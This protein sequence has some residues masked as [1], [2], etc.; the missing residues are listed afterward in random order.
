MISAPRCIGGLSLR[1]TLVR[2][3]FAQL[4]PQPPPAGGENV[5]SGLWFALT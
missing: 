4:S 5:I 2:H 3:I 1:R